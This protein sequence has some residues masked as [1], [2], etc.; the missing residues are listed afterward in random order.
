G[1]REPVFP[2]CDRLIIGR[3]ERDGFLLRV[4][5]RNERGIAGAQ[6]RGL[7]IEL[8]GVDD[9]RWHRPRDLDVDLRH[10]VEAIFARLDAQRVMAGDDVLRQLS[11]RRREREARLGADGRRERNAK[12]GEYYSGFKP[13][14]LTTFRHNWRSLPISARN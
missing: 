3:A 8:G 5:H 9:D 13:I 4:E 6:L 2:G 12:R 10:A 14:S 7:E 11:R 1:N